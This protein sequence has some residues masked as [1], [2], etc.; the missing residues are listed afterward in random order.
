MEKG[1]RCGGVVGGVREG[2]L[3]LYTAGTLC[4]LSVLCIWHK[5]GH[6][7]LSKPPLGFLYLAVGESC[8]QCPG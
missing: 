2:V 8:N 5:V 4:F 6:E 7:A 1:L 3:T